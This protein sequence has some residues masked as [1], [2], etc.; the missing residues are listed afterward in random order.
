MLDDEPADGVR[1]VLRAEPSG[2]EVATEADENGI[3]SGPFGIAWP[4]SI[5]PRYGAADAPLGS[6]PRFAL[7]LPAARSSHSSLGL[8]PP[9]PRSSTTRSVRDNCAPRARYGPSATTAPVTIGVLQDHVDRLAGTIVMNDEWRQA[10]APAVTV[11]LD[12]E[13]DLAVA[14]GVRARLTDCDPG[15]V[16][17]DCL[18]DHRI[19]RADDVARRDAIGG[20]LEQE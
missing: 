12:V 13:L 11:H 2:V 10:V 17:G 19:G 14:I 20:T 1:V 7:I 9:N 8:S 15:T 5:L 4:S 16:A 3:A 18:D 6:L